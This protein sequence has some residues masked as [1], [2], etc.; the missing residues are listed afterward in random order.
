VDEVT[1]IQA[2]TH[3]R[4]IKCIMKRTTKKRRLM[5]NILILITTEEKLINT[6]HA[7]TSELINTRMAITDAT[8]DKARRDEKGMDDAF[9]ELDHLRH[10]EKYYQYSTQATMF[11]RSE[12]QDTYAKFMNEQN[13][14]TAS[15]ADFQEDTLMELVASMDMERWYEKSHQ[16]VEMIDYISTIQKGWDTEENKIRVL[17]DNNI[18]RIRKAIEYWVKKTQE[19]QREIQEKWDE[20]EKRWEK[21]NL[22]MKYICLPEFDSPEDFVNLHDIVKEH[23]EKELTWTSNIEKVASMAPG[24]V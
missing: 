13:L 15:I 24:Q 11:L 1:E 9:K 5:L 6:K 20:C 12:F 17:R 8:L 7:K 2:I 19:P 10:L 14:F 21:I 3:D 23:A 16:V 18:D 22:E 4:K